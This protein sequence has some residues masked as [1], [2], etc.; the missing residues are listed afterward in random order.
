MSPK[1][2]PHD[3]PEGPVL[4]ELE[5]EPGS[6]ASRLLLLR[7]GLLWAVAIFTVTIF[8]GEYLVAAG[9]EYTISESSL[10]MGRAFWYGSLIGLI[11][12][13]WRYP[14][15]VAFVNFQL[16]AAAFYSACI[17]MQMTRSPLGSNGWPLDYEVQLFVNIMLFFWFS[18]AVVGGLVLALGCR[19]N[20]RP[21]QGGVVS[22]CLAILLAVTGGYAAIGFAYMFF[23][24]DRPIMA[25]NSPTLA[26]AV[27]PDMK[28]IATQGNNDRLVSLRDVATGCLLDRSPSD[29]GE[30]RNCLALQFVGGPELLGIA[31]QKTDEPDG[32]FVLQVWDSTSGRD[33]F[34][35]DD[36]PD[37]GRCR[38]V[39]SR[40]GNSF[41]YVAK[42]G[43]VRVFDLKTQ[44]VTAEIPL[45]L[46][47][48]KGDVFRGDGMIVGLAVTTSCGVLAC[49]TARSN[50]AEVEIWDVASA[51]Q[52]N[53]I[54]LER[55]AYFLDFSPDGH[56]LAFDGPSGREILV[57][58]MAEVDK[59][60]RVIGWGAHR[61]IT[62]VAFSPDG[63]ILACGTRGGATVLIDTQQCKVVATLRTWGGKK[64]EH[65][66]F[67]ADGSRLVT[68]D[69]NGRIDVWDVLAAMRRAQS[70]QPSP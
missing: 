25:F 50:G 34:R 66:A 58:N 64:T 46:K 24:E 65:L 28:T 45:D 57:F 43:H 69:T 12:I 40:D 10:A 21:P 55:C 59:P 7:V 11:I 42:G 47:R 30:S 22:W 14:R 41:V 29:G 70:S 52:K 48:A 53:V 68:G 37:E 39:F 6:D 63:A 16:G 19:R 33:R 5:P 8:F 31:S 9:G 26:V 44:R 32:R 49:S 1:Q 62:S 36:D 18:T 51:K 27:S 17:V 20:G 61:S 15:S 56:L 54:Q 3:T 4:A 60:A 13:F 2:T 35:W 23:T 67:F 38:P